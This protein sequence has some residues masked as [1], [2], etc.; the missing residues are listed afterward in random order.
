[1]V[2]GQTRPHSPTLILPI[3][4][5]HL[6]P[7]P[8]LP[9]RAPLPARR[10]TPLAALVRHRP[11]LVL[12]QHRRP[13]LYVVFRISSSLILNFFL[14]LF[15]RPRLRR[16]ALPVALLILPPVPL[17]RALPPLPPP[18]ALYHPPAALNRLLLPPPQL[19]LLRPSLN[20]LLVQLPFYLIPLP[21]LQLLAAPLLL[22]LNT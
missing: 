11:L 4:L 17:K 13:R 22:L 6:L 15:F 8:Q 16:A 20:S 14:T 18:Q 9:L 19:L 5:I 1:M 3:K 21:P 7:L 10:R 12:A 2:L